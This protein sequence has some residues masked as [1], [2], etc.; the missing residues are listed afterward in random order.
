M[1][2]NFRSRLN[3]GMVWVGRAGT[4]GKRK[5]TPERVPKLAGFMP[6]LMARLR[7]AGG[8]SKQA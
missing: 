6:K 7:Y 2:S 5:G 3:G 4:V 8:C 1:V